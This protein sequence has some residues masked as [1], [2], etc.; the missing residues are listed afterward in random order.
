MK[1]NRFAIHC[2]G[3]H[4]N[5]L[6]TRFSKIFNNLSCIYDGDKYVEEKNF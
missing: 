4:T 2:A 6:L 3:E 1:N 5:L